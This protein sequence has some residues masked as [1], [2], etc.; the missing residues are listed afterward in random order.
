MPTLFEFQLIEILTHE[1]IRHNIHY[2][3]KN[4]LI[5]LNKK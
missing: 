5:N 1:K 2:Y 3:S 4:I